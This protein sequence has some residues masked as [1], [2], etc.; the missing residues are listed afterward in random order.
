MSVLFLS[1]SGVLTSIN[2]TAV[3]N[4]IIQRFDCV[5][6]TDFPLSVLRIRTNVL[7][8]LRSCI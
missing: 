6:P 8:E 3:Y 2:K 7:V 1:K 5:D 4:E